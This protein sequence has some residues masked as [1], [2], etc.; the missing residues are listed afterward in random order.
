[1]NDSEMLNRYVQSARTAGVQVELVASDDLPGRLATLL[2]EYG[3]L[4]GSPEDAPPRIAAL[5]SSGWPREILEVVE[6]ALAASGFA[7][8]KPEHTVEGQARNSDRLAEAS[9][10]ITFCA[11]F[12]AETGSMALPASPG[13][14]TL[15]ALL[16]KLHVALSTPDGCRESLADY[17]SGLSG[18]LPSRLTLVTGPSRTGDIEATM[19]VGVHGPGKVIHLIVTGRA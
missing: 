7:V 14:C 3:G 1:M 15:A 4:T 2:A 11:A 16:P 9:I 5:P 10:G 19:T 17:L 18:T 6:S 13:A 8:V 12:L